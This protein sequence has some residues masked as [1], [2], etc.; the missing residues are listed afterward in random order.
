M[1][2]LYVL[3]GVQRPRFRDAQR[4]WLLFEQAA[5]A[6]VSPERGEGEICCRYRTPPGARASEESSVLFKAGAIAGERLY[7]CTSTEVMVFALPGFER[8]G[9]LSLPFFN[10]LHHVAPTP[11]GTLVVVVTGLDMVAEVTLEGELVRCWSALGGDPWQRFSR[12]V[13]YR[14]VATLKPYR[15]H[16]NFAFWRRGELWVN[17]GDLGDAI[18][19]DHPERRIALGAGEC[20]HDGFASHGKIYFT[21]VDGRL[22]IV[23]EDS[24]RLEQSIVL[25]DWEPE[26]RRGW[27]WCRGV[28][29]VG[30]GRVWVGFTR[31][32]RTQWQEKVRWVKGLVWGGAR[33]TRLALY[34]L[35]ARRLVREVDMEPLGLHAVFNALPAPAAD[36]G[37]GG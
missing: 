33:P 13:D 37:V 6:R 1:G 2:D 8:L 26:A 19:L 31:I 16:A 36:G 24:L 35:G 22:M 20:T 29:P 7:A 9:Y 17:R 10:D 27:S 28:L 32:R 21:A 30:E 34:D 18:C 5:V 25:S 11:W 3:G 15:A 23:D 14:Q 12:G 4:E